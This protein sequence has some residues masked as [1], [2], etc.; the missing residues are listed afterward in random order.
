MARK[1]RSLAGFNDFANV[2]ENTNVNND[3]NDNKNIN[4]NNNIN[5]NK[6]EKEPDYLNAIKDIVEKKPKKDMKPTGIYFD[7]NVLKVL[8]SLAKKGGRGAK[9]RI[10]NDATKAAFIQAGLLDEDGNII[11]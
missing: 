3:D 9:S 11:K 10:V 4:V 5:E 1:D 6:E 7:E 8:D 2:N